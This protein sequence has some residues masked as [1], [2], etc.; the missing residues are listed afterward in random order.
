MILLVVLTAVFE[1][2]GNF[3]DVVDIILNMTFMNVR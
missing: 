1:A 2:I 3:V